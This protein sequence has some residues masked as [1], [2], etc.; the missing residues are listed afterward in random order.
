MAVT[1]VELKLMRYFLCLGTTK[2]DIRL[3]KIGMKYN[4]SSNSIQKSLPPFWPDLALVRMTADFVVITLDLLLF[5]VTQKCTLVQS[6]FPFI[7]QPKYK[8]IEFI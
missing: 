1:Y 5:K 8:C 4:L 6:S 2:S 3:R 7:L